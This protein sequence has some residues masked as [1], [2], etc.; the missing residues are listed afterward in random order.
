MIKLQGFEPT[1]N[2][3]LIKRILQPTMTKV[4]VI[5]STKFVDEQS[6]IGKVVAVGKGKFSD[7]GLR[8]KPVVKVGDI[9]LLPEFGGSK[10]PI[11]D[12]KKNEYVMCNDS[13]IPAILKGFKM[14]KY[15]H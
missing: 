6:K 10:V 12:D 13:D 7:Q 9:V 15:K 4:G 1:L 5:L 2:R 11:A 14:S 8:I 3:V